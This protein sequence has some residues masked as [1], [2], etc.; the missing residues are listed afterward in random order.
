MA[1]LCEKPL[2]L[3][4]HSNIR[5]ALRHLVAAKLL[6]EQASCADI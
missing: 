3:T 2:F 4:A 1:V 5:A 6:D